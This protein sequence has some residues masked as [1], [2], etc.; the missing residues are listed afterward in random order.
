WEFKHNNP[1][2]ANDWIVSARK[3]YSPALNLVFAD[4]FYD[5][6]WLQTQSTSSGAMASTETAKV[7]PPPLESSPMA[8]AANKPVQQP[9]E[10]IAEKT[11]ATTGA[12]ES[13]E[14][15]PEI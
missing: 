9:N 3:I 12:A 10:N 14:A 7:E 5:L 6:G 2:K 8:M 15:R 13:S 4:P 11:T 1:A